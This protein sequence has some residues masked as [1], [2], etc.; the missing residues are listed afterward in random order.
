MQGPWLQE[1]RASELSEPAVC[2]LLPAGAV[3]LV[4]MGYFTLP[5]MRR[6]GQAGC[7][8]LSPAK[9]ALVYVDRRGQCW[10][11]LSLLRAQPG[12]VV[13]LD[14]YAGKQDRLPV[15]LIARRVSPEQA[16]QRRE[17]ANKE[18][19]RH[20]KGCQ[21]RGRRPASGGQG[22]TKRQRSRKRKKVS[23]RR[24]HLAEWTILLTNVPREQLSVEE[25]LVLARWSFQI[26]LLW[27]LWK[28]YDKLDSWYSE[29]PY[30]ILTEIYAKLLGLLI[31]HWLTL[32]GCWQAPNR[33]LV[34][35]K[36][37]G[38]WMSP[39]FALAFAGWVPVPVVVEQTSQIMASG[40]TLTS[41]RKRPNTYQL[42]AH[43]QLIRGL[44]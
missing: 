23:V 25:A 5:Q 26:E 12:D 10:D 41:R 8:W 37:V 30:R 7:Y 40:C 38:Q 35:A 13:D 42:V 15:R 19:E 11:L 1:G 33:S 31:T 17:R 39:C 34:K 36:Q 24:L 22:R 44:G 3:S 32:I 43:P 28:Q 21:R 18:V 27:K 4:D 2:T 16:K 20:G 9:A 29:K 6:Q 14:V